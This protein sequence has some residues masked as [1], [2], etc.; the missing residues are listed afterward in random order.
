MWIVIYIVFMAEMVSVFIVNSTDIGNIYPK[1][2]WDGITFV[3]YLLLNVIIVKYL[4]VLSKLRDFLLYGYFGC[5]IIPIF[6]SFTADTI[7]TCQINT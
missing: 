7:F 2:L 6:P 5:S 3:Y 4:S 1:C